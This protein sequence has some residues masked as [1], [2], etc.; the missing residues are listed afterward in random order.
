M[1]PHLETTKPRGRRPQ[2]HGRGVLGLAIAAGL[3]T[4]A[5]AQ[6]SDTRIGELRDPIARGVSEIRQFD[7]ARGRMSAQRPNAWTTFIE[8]RATP[9]TGPQGTWSMPLSSLRLSGRLASGEPWVA[10][11]WMV[12][13]VSGG[14]AYLPRDMRAGTELGATDASGGSI[15]VVGGAGAD[16][17]TLR[18]KAAGTVPSLCIVFAA[19]RAA[20]GAMTLDAGGKQF[21]LVMSVARPTGEPGARTFDPMAW[22]RAQPRWAQAAAIGLAALAIAASLLL[23]R[24]FWR[25]RPAIAAA[26]PQSEPSRRSAAADTL[27]DSADIPAVRQEHCPTN[28]HPIGLRSGD[29]MRLFDEGIH[30]LSMQA[31]AQAEQRLT[32]A[33]AAGVAP[34]YLCGAL[35]FA[36]MASLGQRQLTRAVGYFLAALA[37]EQPTSEGAFRAASCLAAIYAAL[38]RRGDAAKMRAVRDSANARHQFAKVSML[39]LAEELAKAH[40]ARLA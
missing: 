10:A 32:Q 9:D 1:E 17:R 3:A 14:C 5:S 26:A 20:A 4:C 22:V 16:G 6:G 37:C 15:S 31:H 40:L 11:P 29:G 24:R 36:G 28:F 21:P 23:R 2:R 18:L 8:V 38:G 25:G 39:K 7:A 33:M 35:C 13:S 30:L 19:P 12:G 34:T 27:P